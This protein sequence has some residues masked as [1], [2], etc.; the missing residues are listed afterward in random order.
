MIKRGLCITL[1][2]LDTLSAKHDPD[3]VTVLV[4]LRDW[5]RCH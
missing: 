4:C 2:L 3:I 5:C 1:V